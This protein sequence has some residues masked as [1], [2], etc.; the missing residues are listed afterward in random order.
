MDGAFLHGRRKIHDCLRY[1]LTDGSILIGSFVEICTLRFRFC[2]EYRVMCQFL[3][4]HQTKVDL[5][6][7]NLYVH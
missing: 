6:Q 4:A 7:Q 3:A 5:T 2:K 1:V